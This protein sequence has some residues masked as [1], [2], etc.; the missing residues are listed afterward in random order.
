DVKVI[1]EDQFEEQDSTTNINLNEY[2]LFK[3]SGVYMQVVE[4]GGGN[5]LKCGTRTLFRA[6][7]KPFSE[8]YKHKYHNGG[9]VPQI[10]RGACGGGKI[11]LLSVDER[12]NRSVQAPNERCTGAERNERIHIRC[13]VEKCLCAGGEKPY[14]QNNGKCRRNQLTKRAVK[15]IYIPV[16][17]CGHGKLQHM[18]HAYVHQYGKQ[19]GRNG[20]AKRNKPSCLILLFLLA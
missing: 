3:E 6:L 14:V 7:L 9:F 2:V 5:S 10:H 19:G 4:R 12:F 16:Q 15:R 17:E 8:R 20:K 18:P 11:S 1:D 13:A